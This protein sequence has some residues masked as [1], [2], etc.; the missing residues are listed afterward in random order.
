MKILDGHIQT[1]SLPL[2][3]GR[4]THQVTSG[5]QGVKFFY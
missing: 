5:K 4:Y 3:L 2:P 1:E